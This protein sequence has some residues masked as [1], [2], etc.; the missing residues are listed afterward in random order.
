MVGPASEMCMRVKWLDLN[1]KRFGRGL[2]GDLSGPKDERVAVL[3]G[4]KVPG[5]NTLFPQASL[6]ADGWKIRAECHGEEYK[7]VKYPGGIWHLTA[8]VL[9]FKMAPG[10]AGSEADFLLYVQRRGERTHSSGK[11]AQ[12]VGGHVSFG[13]TPLEAALKET[14]EE[15]GV[16]LS[17]GDL[18]E[19]ARFLHVSQG[20]KNHEVASLFAA[21][22]AKP[23]K[24][25]YKEVSWIEPFKLEDVDLLF[26]YCP[27]EF[28]K[29][30]QLDLIWLR[31]AIEK[32]RAGSSGNPLENLLAGQIP[33]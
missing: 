30:F 33:A 25:N 11:L 15:A 20:G 31:M 9:M 2:R 26:K 16:M 4:S 10:E 27:Q 1:A 28:S 29:S 22:I 13:L 23:L 6:L 18:S 24:P 5:L 8:H 12:S 3:S 14:R 21:Q 32:L 19:V 17:P 7:G